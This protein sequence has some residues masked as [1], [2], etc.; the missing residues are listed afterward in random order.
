MLESLE[1]PDFELAMATL[2]HEFSPRPDQGLPAEAAPEQTVAAV[3][4][5]CRRLKLSNE[6]SD[7]IGWLVTHQH[8]IRG[9]REQPLSRTKRLLASPL[10]RDLL[11]LNRAEVLAS[12]GSLDAVEFCEEKL[13]TWTAAEINPPPI[14]SGDD[15]IRHGLRPGA[16]FKNL[17]E[18]VRD[19][20]LEGKIADK[21]AALAL[22][23]RLRAKPG[24]DTKE[25]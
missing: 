7:R 10:I 13:R 18:V 14:L 17:L 25:V 22:V 9:L 5:L 2:F 1:D 8:A 24:A 16:E 3:H 20:Q 21:F 4:V 15:L 6:E 23:D 12:D 11:A 19:A